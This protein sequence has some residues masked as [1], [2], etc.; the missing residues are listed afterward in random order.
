[1]VVFARSRDVLLIR[2]LG[3]PV[4]ELRR[5]KPGESWFY[6][7]LLGGVEAV[8]YEVRCYFV[9]L[10]VTARRPN[11]ANCLSGPLLAHGKLAIWAK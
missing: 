3:A 2:K 8:A 4:V 1:V 10:E 7:A 5:S 9:G 6:A 11:T